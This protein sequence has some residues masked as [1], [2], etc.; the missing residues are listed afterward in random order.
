MQSRFRKVNHYLKLLDEYRISEK[1]EIKN[2]KICPCGYKTDNTPPPPCDF[3]SFG[4]GEVWGQGFDT[5]AWFHMSHTVKPKAGHTA[6][7]YFHTDKGGWD[8]D[9]PQFICYING[10]MRQGLDINHTFVNVDCDR[11]MDIYLYAYVGTINKSARLYAY[12]AYVCDEVDG[13]WYD[14]KVPFDM[15][16]YL[17]ENSKEYME[18]LSY[19]YFAVSKLD[20]LLPGNADF[21]ASVTRARKYLEEEFYGKYCS[22]SSPKTVCIGHTHI[23]CAWKWTLRQTRE[24][25]QRSF[26][27]VLELMNR[28]PEYK[29]MSSQAL[30]YKYLKEEAPEVYE[31]VK[32][33]IKEG[34]WECEGAMWVEADCNLTS[35]ESLVRQVLYG[36]R[37]F[38]EEFGLDHKILWLPDVFGYSAALPQILRKSGVDWFVTSKISWNDSN[39][40][41]HDT[42]MWYGI[43]GTPIRTHFLTANDKTRGAAPRYATYVGFTRAP[44]LT[45]TYD[46]YKDKYLN[47]E[48][49][50]TFGYG[51]GG[52][53]PTAR[54]LEYLRRERRGIPGAPTATVEFATD[55]LD[56]LGKKI[57]NNPLLPSWRGELYLEFHRG[58]YTS[59]SKNKR[60]N[61]KSEFLYMNAELYSSIAKALAGAPYG[62]AA[63]HSGWEDILTNQFHDIIPGSSIKEVYD[64]SD[65]DYAKI[66]SIGESVSTAAKAAIAERISEDCGYV[67]FNPNSFTRDL[68]V[69]IDGVSK[70]AKDVPAKGYAAMCDFDADSDI[71]IEGR[72]VENSAIRVEFDEN[73]LI[74]SIFFKEADREVVKSGERANEIRIYPDFPDEYD[75]WE[76]QEYSKNGSYITLTELS[77]VRVIKDGVRCAIEIVRPH[78]ESTITQRIWFTKGSP[79][80]DFDVVADWHQR[81]QMVKVAFPTDINADKATYEVQFG[82]VERPTH[83][84]TSWDKAK[85]EVCAQKFA[86][87]SEG[88][89]GVGLMNDCKYGHDIHDGVM[90]LSLFKSPTEPNPEADQGIIEFTYAICPHSGAFKDSDIRQRAYV[91]NNPADAIKATGKKSSI[92]E[93]FSFVCSDKENVIIETV[94][95]AED[96]EATV[97]RL[98]ESSNTR[99]RVTLTVGFPADKCYLCNLLEE[100][101]EELKIECGKVTLNV[102]AFD[103][104]TLK[105]I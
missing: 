75:A 98:Y 47:D 34:R 83:F 72:V 104:V 32:E 44:M 3:R 30:L 2:I 64:D 8:A 5:H 89:F 105:F 33:R 35:G 25:V 39:T 21:L 67:V 1:N 73:Y 59:I 90:M 6:R 48:A 19:L 94:K 76:W 69:K 18:I 68:V 42:F 101:E 96:S 95:E 49:I 17:D 66:K 63:L 65:L 88:N 58:T 16:S 86:D 87:L 36:K 27:T 54:D 56:R 29:F 28:Y 31:R 10:E 82:T 78:M 38:K 102:R 61:R 62:K 22:P 79:E 84:N 26:S 99:T 100:E 92:P 15:L 11:E 91:L 12:E 24:K 97:I 52:G 40:M 50:L 57:E 43:D 20:M 71:V 4:E 81:H 14:L 9:N 70:I 77:E 37:F 103:I 51:D 60:N 23:D 85:F 74:K 13:L 53:G 93:K 46:R 7:L 45:G 80:I 55:Y 41:P